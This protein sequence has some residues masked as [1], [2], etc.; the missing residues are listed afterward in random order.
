MIKSV[1]GSFIVQFDIN[2]LK[3]V[4]DEYGHSEGDKHISAAASVI[5]ASFGADG[6][7]FRTGGDEFI[8][9]LAGG[10]CSDRKMKEFEQRI[11]AYNFANQPPVPLVIAVGS[12]E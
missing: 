5:K 9:I 11:S 12:A 4:N 7:I 6:H 1:V 8:A 3:K 10:S 2:D